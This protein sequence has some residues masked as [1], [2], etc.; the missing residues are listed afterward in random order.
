MR[1]E[2]I[3]RRAKE[4]LEIETQSV[5]KLKERVGR[6]FVEAVNIILSCRG[7]VVVTG[8]GK[9]GIVGKKIASTLASTG[10]P[11]FF[12]HPAEGIHGDLGMVTQEDVVLAISYSGETDEVVRLIPIIK[13]IGAKLLSLT[14]EP[15]STLGRNSLVVMDVSV[16]REAC[17][18]NLAPTSST[19]A[20]LAAGDALA[21]VLAEARQFGREDFAFFHPGGALG[22]RLML[23]VR[24]VMRTGT[25][26]PVV[27]EDVTMQEA[28][29]EMTRKGLGCTTVVDENGRLVGII[30]DGDLRRL[31]HKTDNPLKMRARD[32]MT[33]KPK[34]IEADQLAAKA[35]EKMEKNA[36]TS[37]VIVDD[38]DKIVGIVHLH[39]LLGREEFRFGW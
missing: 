4:A 37:L 15:N 34:T 9:S 31:L 13:K 18:L 11:A 14:G 2:E 24:D 8:M 35:V 29:E 22:R 23:R 19:T 25:D 30:T 32:V 17:P 26:I 33:R 36:I 12:L 16:E 28:I 7:R 20:T 38:E 5:A 10:T 3:I 1:D 21:V 6:N 39:D 27:C